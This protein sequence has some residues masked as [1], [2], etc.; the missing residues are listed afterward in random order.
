MAYRRSRGVRKA[1]ARSVLLVVIKTSGIARVS[2][3]T[4]VGHTRY[5]A[6]VGGVV[7]V[8]ICRIA[9]WQTF[10]NYGARPNLAIHIGIQTPGFAI[11][12]VCPFVNG[13]SISAEE[14]D[15]IA[16]IVLFSPEFGPVGCRVVGHHLTK[17]FERLLSLARTRRYLTPICAKVH[18]TLETARPQ[19]DRRVVAD[20]QLNR[21]PK[22]FVGQ[23]SIVVDPIVANHR[24]GVVVEIDARIE[25][26][27]AK[28][29]RRDACASI[30]QQTQ[31]S[32]FAQP[33]RAV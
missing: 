20:A 24:F 16:R 12:F 28:G 27:H 3:C 29:F 18:N 22:T 6:L 31:W 1:F 25:H 2:R 33:Y 26:R 21:F 7:A 32:C 30:S 5:C 8:P 10:G 13:K 19:K 14:W 17:P 4:A 9:L 15:V 23:G 11:G